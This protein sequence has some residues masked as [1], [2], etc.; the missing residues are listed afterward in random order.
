MILTGLIDPD[1]LVQIAHVYLNECTSDDLPK[2]MNDLLKSL[3]GGVTAD[4]PCE[5]GKRR[6]DVLADAAGG[7]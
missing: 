7:D 2:Q 1:L 3:K 4:E 6:P 5:A